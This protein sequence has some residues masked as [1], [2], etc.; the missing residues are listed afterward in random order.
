MKRTIAFLLP[1][2]SVLTLCG[3][4]IF[5]SHSTRFNLARIE[6]K[7]NHKVGKQEILEKTKIELGANLFCMDLGRIE[8]SIREDERIKDVRVKRKPPNQLLIEVEEKRPALWIN[9]PEGLYGLSP[10]QEIIPLE[11]EDFDRD[12]PIVTGLFPSALAERDKNIIPYQRWPDMKAKFAFD[13]FN[14]VMENDSS[15]LETISEI[16]LG[17]QN[18]LVLYLIPQGTQVNMGKGGLKRKLRRLKAILHH[19]RQSE[20]LGC[21]DLRFK[22]QVVLR[23]PLPGSIRF[24]SQNPDGRWA[25]SSGGDSGGKEN[26]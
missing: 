24:A 13:F 6:I 16:S 11:E 25:H 21:I 20:Y 8:D 7:G 23:K 1:I 3:T 10:D 18:N 26:F 17:D 9:L 12:L 4:Y 5:V 15:F 14:T 19:E 2:L 22:N